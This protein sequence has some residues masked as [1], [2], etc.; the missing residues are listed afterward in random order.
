LAAGYFPTDVVIKP[1]L[2]IRRRQASTR[3]RVTTSQLPFPKVGLRRGISFARTR[4]ASMV[5]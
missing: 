1:N 4:A 5:F 3:L 2:I